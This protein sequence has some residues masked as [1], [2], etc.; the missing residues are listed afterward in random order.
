MVIRRHSREE[1]ETKRGSSK[2]S[3]V[4]RGREEAGATNGSV[5]EMKVEEEEGGKGESPTHR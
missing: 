1:P 3:T 5:E 2:Y 4:E